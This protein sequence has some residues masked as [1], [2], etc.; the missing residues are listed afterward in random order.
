MSN[1]IA[2]DAS[3]RLRRDPQMMRYGVQQ[4]PKTAAFLLAIP[5]CVSKEKSIQKG[6]E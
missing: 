2:E 1:T 6:E 5:R 4:G 3:Y